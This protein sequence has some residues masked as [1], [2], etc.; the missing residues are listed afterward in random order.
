[1]MFST[2]SNS[3]QSSPKNKKKIN[4]VVELYDYAS[5]KGYDVHFYDLDLDGLES[6]STMRVRDRK[7]FVAIDPYKI[8]SVAD[9]LTKGLHEIGHCDTGAFYNEDSPFDIRMK[10]ENKAWKQAISLL[11]SPED[12]DAAVA[13]GYTEI[14]SLAEHF[15][16]TEELMQKAVCWY[17]HGNLAAELYF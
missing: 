16:I 13:D 17:T 4:N 11:L 12:L 8:Q 9:E 15:G 5:E 6:I 3:L 2:G 1:M 10:H 7:C 14:W